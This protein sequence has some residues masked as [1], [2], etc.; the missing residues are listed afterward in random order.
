MIKAQTMAKLR[1]IHQYIGLFFAPMI[2]LFALSGALQTFRLQETHDPAAPPPPAWIVWL[3]SVHKDQSLPH[4]SPPKPKPGPEAGVGVD[5]GRPA[6]PGRG[7][8]GKQPSRHSTLPLKIF[9][10]LLSAGLF[11]S[12]LL[13]VVIALNNR[14]ARRAS[15]AALIAGAILP[16]LLLFV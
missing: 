13:G 5:H 14:A 15:I 9:V 2:L 7:G 6:G 4:P 3:A 1:K 10:A 16:L 11:M 8:E 12:T